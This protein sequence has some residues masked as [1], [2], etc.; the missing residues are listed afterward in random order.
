MNVK[1]G[2]ENAANALNQIVLLLIEDKQHKEQKGENTEQ[3]SG[4]SKNESYLLKLL[5]HKFHAGCIIG[6]AGSIVKQIAQESGAR[7]QVST[8]PL[9]GSNEKSVSITGTPSAIQPALIRILNQIK[10]NPIRGS[11]S[12]LFVPGRPVYP[13]QTTAFYPPPPPGSYPGVNPYA[14]FPQT[15]GP[16]V[17]SSQ[18]IAIPAASA[19]AVIGKG[20]TIIADIKNQSGCT[21]RIANPDQNN[22]NERVVTVTGPPEGIQTA[23]AMIRQRVEH[24]SSYPGLS[25][26]NPYAPY[27]PTS[28]ETSQKIAIPTSCAGAVIGK[29]G[30]IVADIKH[31][32]GCTIRIADPDQNNPG[33]RIVTVSGS[34][35]GIQTAVY[36]IRQRVEHP[37]APWGVG[38]GIPYGAEMINPA[39]Q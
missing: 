21:I 38:V 31:Q 1:G 18:K 23:V 15:Q 27:Q 11:P 33:E 39:L 24:P 2:V 16:S 19:G 6:K 14:P 7:V 5:V 20:G 8:D 35:Q 3:V 17:E 37:Y 30:T 10:E 34:P 29:N 12:L 4:D 36:L 26:P 9:P 13:P 28:L 32:S 22:Q 25:T